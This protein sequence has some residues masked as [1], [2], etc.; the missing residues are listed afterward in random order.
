ML[1]EVNGKKNYII[2]KKSKFCFYYAV[3]WKKLADDNIFEDFIEIINN[4]PNAEEIYTILYTIYCAIP[5]LHKKYLID[6]LDNF[7]NAIMNFINNLDTKEIR[8]LPKN[9]S[10]IFFKFLK[11]INEINPK[12]R[13]TL[14][15][16]LDKSR[17]LRAN[18]MRFLEKQNAIMEL[19]AKSIISTQEREAIID[20]LRK[21]N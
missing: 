6:N 9:I 3:F 15:Q 10:D 12:T 19:E 13:E 20:L 4:K 2:G 14:E 16:D 7:K 18:A 5:Y 21:M 17:L 11:S 8:N 1:F